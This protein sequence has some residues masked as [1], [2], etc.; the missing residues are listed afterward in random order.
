MSKGSV[1]TAGGAAATAVPQPLIAH[2]SMEGIQS[3][4]L[5]TACKVIPVQWSTTELLRRQLATLRARCDTFAKSGYSPSALKKREALVE[6]QLLSRA[7][8]AFQLLDADGV[9]AVEVYS[10]IHWLSPDPNAASGVDAEGEEQG[11]DAGH[12][13]EQ[14]V[15]VRARERC[16]G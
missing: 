15:K 1:P 2:L 8:A 6:P 10:L 9:G 11:G 14:W 16:W 4:N 3:P 5:V 12:S 7:R 13:V